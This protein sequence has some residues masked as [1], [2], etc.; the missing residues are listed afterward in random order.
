MTEALLRRLRELDVR[1][2]A[3]GEVL[4]YDAPRAAL[5]PELLA[6]LKAHKAALLAHLSGGPVSMQQEAMA[7][8][9][10]TAP[11]P[12]VYNVATRLTFTGRVDPAALATALTELLARHVAL[13]SRFSDATGEWRH[14]ELP[15]APVELPVREVPDVTAACEA[16]AATPIDLSRSTT[17]LCGLFRVDDT[18]WVLMLVLHHI[19]VDGWALSLVLRELAELYRAALAGTPAELAPPAAQCTDHARWQRRAQDPAVVARKLANWCRRLAPITLTLTAPTD[20]PRPPERSGRGGTIRRPVPGSTRAAVEAFARSRG[21]TP[22]AVTASALATTLTEDSLVFNVSYANR[23]RREFESMVD[24]TVMG[25]AV[26]VTVTD[27]FGETVDRTAL[28]ALEGL[29][30]LMPYSRILAHLREH[31]TDVP[32]KSPVAFTYQNFPP[33]PAAFA[34]LPVLVE[35]LAPPA[36]RTDLAIGLTPCAD[37]ADGYR[38]FLEYSA[39]LWERESAEAML[40]RFAAALAAV[41]G[42]G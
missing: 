14:H 42:A 13:R 11:A 41:P 29:D 10:A 26:P 20:H 5:T 40:D 16:L 7:G 27:D 4:R 3:A 17:P 39:D 18:H 6:E 28:A 31:R 32:P 25:L 37:P 38:A 2:S 22:F 24:C 21:C 33:P 1:L 36:S 30:D 19:T 9:A 12:Q 8:A 35:D 34:D 15:P 23:E